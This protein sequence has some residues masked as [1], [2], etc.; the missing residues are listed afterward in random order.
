MAED[1]PEMAQI[2]N[3]SGAMLADF[4]AIKIGDVNGNAVANSLVQADDRTTAKIFEISTI[5]KELKAGETYM[6]TFSTKQ[7]KEIQGYQFT[8]AYN[9]LQIEKLT[10]GIAKVENFGLHKMDDGYITT[11]WN[12]KAES[13]NTLSTHHPHVS[14]LFT[15]EFTA[16]QNGRLSEQLAIL[17]RPTVIEAYDENGAVMDI[18]LTFTNSRY[19]ESF[20]LFQNQPNPFYDKTMI[21]FYLPGDSE[22]Q[23]ILRDEKGRILKTFKEDRKAGYNTIQLDKEALTNGFIYYQLST[24]YGAQAKKMLKLK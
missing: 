15:I 16:L 1:F 7:I 21:G 10:S 12:Q 6:F 24:K 3:L 23:L 8:L 2:D 5:D 14:D 19:Q 4:V 9:D 20:E 17:N 13:S 18:Q 11:S 22:V